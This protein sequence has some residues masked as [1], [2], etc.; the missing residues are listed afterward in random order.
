MS[1]CCTKNRK[2][3]TFDRKAETSL[4]ACK[5]GREYEKK[6]VNI[7]QAEIENNQSFTDPKIA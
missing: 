1:K 5:M 6:N 7:A 2:Q 4:V 3:I